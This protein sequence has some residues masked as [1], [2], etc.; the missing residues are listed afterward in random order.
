MTNTY[1]DNP[2]L[3][4]LSSKQRE[5]LDLVVDRRTNKE[6][7]VILGISPSA[8]EQRL[9]SVRRKFDVQGRADLARAYLRFVN[10]C[11]NLTGEEKQVSEG[12]DLSTFVEERFGGVGSHASEGTEM[13]AGWQSGGSVNGGAKESAVQR[14]VHRQPVLDRLDAAAGLS[15]RL[16]AIATTAAA[17]AFLVVLMTSASQAMN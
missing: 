8:V 14:M 6:I 15:G 4:D 16:A 12:A 17:F 7:S 2:V 10:A 3:A 1:T 5:V 13:G 9:Q 11:E